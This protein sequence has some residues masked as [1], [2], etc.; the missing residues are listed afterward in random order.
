[1]EE[2]A[3]TELGNGTVLLNMRHDHEE[4]GRAIAISDDGGETFGS[5][6]FDPVLIGPSCEGR[7]DE[8]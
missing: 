3:L 4:R 1:M 2:P 7:C 8:W 6:H 5:I